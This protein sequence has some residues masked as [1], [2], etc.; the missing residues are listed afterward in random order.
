MSSYP[1]RELKE[2]MQRYKDGKHVYN[3]QVQMTYQGPHRLASYTQAFFIENNRPLEREG[4]ST[5]RFE[6]TPIM[7]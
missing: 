5:W 3:N 1:R 2:P 6:K 7:G 4:E